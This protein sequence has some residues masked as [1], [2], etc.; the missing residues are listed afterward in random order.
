MSKSRTV[1]PV[2]ERRQEILSTARR[3]FTSNGYK[4]T[5]VSEIAN[6]LGI[7]QG[8]VFH[9]FK[10]K[11]TLLYSVFDEIAA[12]EQTTMTALFEDYQGRAIDCLSLFFQ[13]S[14]DYR[15]YDALLTDLAS[16]PAV[17]EYL[18]DKVSRLSVPLIKR[19][20]E[21]GNADGS[22]QCDY[23]EQTAIFIIQGC[24]GILKN[25]SDYDPETMKVAIQSILLRLLGVDFVKDPI[26]YGKGAQCCS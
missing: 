12:E 3:L 7:A 17:H 21:R 1:K 25:H 18:Q 24:S 2:E 5:S 14:H 10:S 26:E 20:I 15:G 4:N 16:D 6:E 11:A 9:Y 13:K 22:W 8:L 23:P 19:M